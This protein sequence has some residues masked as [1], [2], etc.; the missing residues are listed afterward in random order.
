MN[1]P[2]RQI[3]S[4]FSAIAP[5]VMDNLTVMGRQHA[6]S[7]HEIS[8]ARKRCVGPEFNGRDVA[9]NRG[10]GASAATSASGSPLTNPTA[11][12]QHRAN[13]RNNQ[14]ASNISTS[15][16]P[17]TSVRL[18]RIP[19]RY[20]KQM[21]Q[22][23]SAEVE[24]GHPE[25]LDDSWPRDFS[26]PRLGLPRGAMADIVPSWQSWGRSSASSASSLLEGGRSDRTAGSEQGNR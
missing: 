26:S 22:A 19:S 9:R 8:L 20:I 3:G 7:L 1:P 2:Y 13:C 5:Q 21:R 10:A 18:L 17:L 16:H 23:H 11:W 25:D 6:S 12:G 15:S 4:Q 14:I 24:A